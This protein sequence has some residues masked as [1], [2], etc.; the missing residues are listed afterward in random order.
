MLHRITLRLPNTRG[1]LRARL[2]ELACRLNR[3]ETTVNNFCAARIS[4]AA[5]W[6]MGTWLDVRLESVVRKREAATLAS[7]L[8]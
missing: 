5:V 8:E 2:S 3:V 6:H 1:Q 7:E 4:D